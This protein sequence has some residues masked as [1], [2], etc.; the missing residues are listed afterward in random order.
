MTLAG[1]FLKNSVLYPL[2]D[3][4][5][6]ELSFNGKD[7]Y[8]VSINKKRQK[9]DIEFD[10][11][12]ANSFVRHIAD[13]TGKSFNNTYPI[14]DVSFD[15]Y[16]LNAIHSSV[17][18]CNNEGTITFIIRKIY[19]GFRIK[20]DDVTLCDKKVHK[21]LAN[22]VALNHSVMISGVTGSGKSELQKYLISL[23]PKYHR[24]VMIE[25][26]YETHVKEL[27]PDLDINI[28][29]ARSA[30]FSYRENLQRLIKAGLRNNPDWLMISEVRGEEMMD[31]LQTVSSGI[32]IIT[33]IHAKSAKDTPSRMLQLMSGSKM[34]SEEQLKSEIYSHIH[35]Y[36]GMAK[37][38]SSD[39]KIKR[40]ISDISLVNYID[41]K[42]VNYPI[43]TNDENNN[44]NFYS[45]DKISAKELK[46]PVDWY[47]EMQK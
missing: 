2:F 6:S 20:K 8:I 37:K 43:Y 35:F 23:V 46:L 27:V 40:Y 26:T 7:L 13:L 4:D 34:L 15:N 21:L 33:T 45:L 25:D 42:Y 3:D 9:C 32:S 30:P 11:E 5:V 31:L 38:Y 17:A 19:E 12:T 41:D 29:I 18:S 22:I 24:I 47:K 14:L 16:R 10:S 39:G 44:K 36:I 28:W 1:E